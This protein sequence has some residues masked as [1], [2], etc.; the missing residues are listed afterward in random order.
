MTPQAAKWLF[1]W[2]RPTVPPDKPLAYGH[3]GTK[4]EIKVQ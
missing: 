1:R 4:V 3:I 2:T